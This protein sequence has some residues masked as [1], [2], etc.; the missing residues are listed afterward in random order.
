MGL[1]IQKES[2]L[3]EGTNMRANKDGL[4]KGPNTR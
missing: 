4:E 3:G 1:K 2:K